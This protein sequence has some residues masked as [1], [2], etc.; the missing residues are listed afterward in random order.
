MDEP[1]STHPPSPP[2]RPPGPPPPTPPAA[3]YAAAAPRPHV[4][5]LVAKP[6]GF[7]RAIGLVFGLFVV[8]AVFL[9]GLTLGIITMVAGGRIKPMIL[10]E[11]FR[12][13]RRD[14]VLICCD[15]YFRR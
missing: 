1:G 14:T 6:G 3:S 11:V 7:A 8:G 12:D 5:Q 15:L 13:G 4:V 2:F 10:E 9:V